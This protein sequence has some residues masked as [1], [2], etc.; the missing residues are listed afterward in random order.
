VGL[1][2]ADPQRYA[3]LAHPGDSFAYDIF[4]QAGQAIRDPAGLSP[5]GDLEPETV[6]AVGESQSALW[7]V[8][9]INAIHP[10][11]G[12]YD[13]FLVHSRGNIS[14]P[15]SQAPQP[16]IGVPL[17]AQIRSD[18]D[19]PVLT[20]ETETD[21]T[22]LGYFGTRQPDSD[23]FRLWEVAGTAHADTYS[24]VVGAVD[25]GDSPAAAQLVLTLPGLPCP[26]PINSGPQHF[27]L[28]AA[29]N[30]L[31]RWVRDGT[32]PAVAPRLNVVA[33]PP[34]AIVRDAFGNARGGIRTPQIDVPIATLSGEGQSGVV[35]SLFGT[36]VVFDLARLQSLYPD[37]NT[38]IAA[39]NQATD[40]AVEAGF[41]LPADGD[42]MK[43][44]AAAG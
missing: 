35:C 31:N 12:I 8:T 40:A 2:A 34:V 10:L 1:R 32:P 27:V 23:R 25:L 4:S 42:L 28:K 7:L 38:Y 17:S 29:I 39:F 19:V 41:I 44:A 9:Y 37:R 13:G 16:E 15:L 14:A 11:A 18:V 22:V 6:I 26:A 36:T 20:F 3:S 43:A 33:G 21:L 30:A 5:L 24:F